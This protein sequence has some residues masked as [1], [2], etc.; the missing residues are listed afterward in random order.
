MT[1]D[2]D[3]AIEYFATG[4]EITGS[5]EYRAGGWKG[6]GQDAE[7]LDVNVGDESVKEESL[8][9]TPMVDVTFLLLIFF[10]VTASFTIQKS[11]AQP[12]ADLGNIEVVDFPQPEPEFVSVLI[13]QND[14]FYVSSRDEEFEC[15][16]EREMRTRL[17]DVAN[18]TDFDRMKILAHADS[19]H[20]KV[21]SAWDAG[22]VAG[23]ENISIE[24]TEEEL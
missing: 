1:S 4:A 2:R 23:I 15:P 16:S 13:D 8:D 10:M 20:Q 17:K 5:G 14:M 11:I 12:P 18:R 6:F 3:V 7:L 9:M 22:V 21:I 19:M 24:M